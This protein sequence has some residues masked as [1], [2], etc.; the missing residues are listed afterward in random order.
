MQ[1]EKEILLKDPFP[2][3]CMDYEEIW[4]AN[5]HSGARIQE[6]S[7]KDL[8]VMNVKYKITTKNNKNNNIINSILVVSVIVIFAVLIE[9]LTL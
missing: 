8:L 4:E 1:K 9:K 7:V 3:R 2:T 6:V 5:N